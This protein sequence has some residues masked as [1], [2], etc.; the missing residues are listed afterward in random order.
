MSNLFFLIGMPGSGKSTIGKR[1]ANRLKMNFLDLDIE[2]ERSNNK[3]VEQIFELE[4]EDYFRKLERKTLEEIIKNNRN[5]I[6]SLGGGTVCFFDTMKLVL[7]KGTVI[8]LQ[9]N[10]EALFKRLHKSNNPRPL[11][12]NLNEEEMKAKIES[13]LN[14]RKPFYEKAHVVFPAI[15]IKLDDLATEVEKIISLKQS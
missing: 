5:T 7:K 4:G 10:S 8:Y 15:N 13:L 11:F 2:I 1:L 12:K 9:A 6:V 3:S 14:K